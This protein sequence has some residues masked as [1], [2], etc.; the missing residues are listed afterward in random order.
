M[1]ITKNKRFKTLF[2]FLIFTLLGSLFLISP[3]ADPF[4]GLYQDFFSTKEQRK[5]P[6]V[7][8]LPIQELDGN[9]EIEFELNLRRKHAVALYLVTDDGVAI[10]DVNT[11][12][13]GTIK[14]MSIDDEILLNVPVSEKYQ[15]GTYPRTLTTFSYRKI[16]RFNKK[17]KL[18]LSNMEIKLSSNLISSNMD[19]IKTSKPISQI[20]YNSLRLRVF[21]KPET[22]LL[23]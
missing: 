2:N 9:H 13:T 11:K 4:Y 6:L 14:I 5:W 21:I 8:D 16:G 7:F 19:E 10:E 15:F 18:T 23:H 17:A 1:I 22:V 20:N 12:V 3:I